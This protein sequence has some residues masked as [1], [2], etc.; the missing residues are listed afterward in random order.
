MNKLFSICILLFLAACSDG[1][2]AFGDGSTSSDDTTDSTDDTGTGDGSGDGSGSGGSGDSTGDTV[3]INEI[4][5]E[6]VGSGLTMSAYSFDDTTGELKLV[7]LPFD[8]SDDTYTLISS[9]ALGNGFSL[10][11]SNPASSDATMQYYAVFR[12]SDSGNSQVVAA[13]TSGFSS[14]GRAGLAATRLNDTITLPSDGNYRYT[15]QYAGLR[16]TEES[17]ATDTVTGDVFLL[18]DFDDNDTGTIVGNI[19]N[20]VPRDAAT[21]AV[22]DPL[23]SV[24]LK[25]SAIDRVNSRVVEGEAAETGDGESGSGSWQAI[26]A[27]P[28]GEEIAGVL[29]LS[30]SSTGPDP[31]AVREVGGFI[32]D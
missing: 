18:I 31:Q 12:R 8:A 2:V 14:L 9:T 32:A 1:T 23:A 21:L 11:E 20:R 29:L 7:D 6:D 24:A 30:D 13:A 5:V 25:T 22:G 28:N 10:Y 27:G 17:S 16:V 26:F 19:T 4:L 15:G 3:A